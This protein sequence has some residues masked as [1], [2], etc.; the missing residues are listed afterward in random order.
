[1]GGKLDKT[2]SL[3]APS[4][5]IIAHLMM[6]MAYF[7][8]N[9]KQSLFIKGTQHCNIDKEGPLVTFVVHTMLAH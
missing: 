7:L 6:E 9:A 5:V 1:M 2:P 4:L 3:D 8:Y